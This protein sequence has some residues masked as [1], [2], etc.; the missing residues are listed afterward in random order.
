MPAGSG[1]R[2]EQQVS[3][4]EVWIG[5]R[6]F[7]TCPITLMHIIIVSRTLN[8]FVLREDLISLEQKTSAWTC[9]VCYCY[10]LHA[11]RCALTTTTNPP[12]DF[13]L[14]RFFMPA[15]ECLLAMCDMPNIIVSTLSS[16]YLRP[17]AYEPKELQWRGDGGERTYETRECPFVRSK[18][19]IYDKTRRFCLLFDGS[20]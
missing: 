20:N 1:P 8:N 13:D 9:L 15:A 6:L 16:S 11:M 18:P 4:S 7:L 14:D 19:S 3:A 10:C 12:M 17:L 2:Y 5:K